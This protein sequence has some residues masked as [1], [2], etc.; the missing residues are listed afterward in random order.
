MTGRLLYRRGSFNGTFDDLILDALLDARRAFG[1][2]QDVA[3]NPFNP[4]P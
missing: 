2:A 3:D 1:G 4:D